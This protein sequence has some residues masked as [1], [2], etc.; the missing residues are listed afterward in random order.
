[1]SSTP[2]ERRAKSRATSGSSDPFSSDST[3]WS[4]SAGCEDWPQALRRA[5][6]LADA[7]ADGDSEIARYWRGEAAKLLAPLLHAAALE[8][9]SMTSVLA[10]LEVV[11]F[12]P[13]AGGPVFT[14]RRHLEAPLAP[15]GRSRA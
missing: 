1:M 10:W 13:G 6:W 2:R 15:A 11:H 3:T 8:G 14:R 4:P 12:S 7:S 9:E 5:Q